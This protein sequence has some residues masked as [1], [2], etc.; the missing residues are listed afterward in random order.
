MSDHIS[1]VCAKKEN[2]KVTGLDN[3]NLA[4]DY[5][6]VLFMISG[7]QH[8]VTENCALLDHYAAS[9]GNSLLTFWDNL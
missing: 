7:F 2:A 8:E 3:L 5:R 9:S 1:P 6:N 4:L